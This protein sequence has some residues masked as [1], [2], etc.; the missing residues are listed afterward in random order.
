MSFSKII[1][2]AIKKYNMLSLV[3]HAEYQGSNI[4]EKIYNNSG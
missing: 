2:W 4:A 1:F 3:I